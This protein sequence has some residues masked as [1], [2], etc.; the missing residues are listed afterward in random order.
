M[1]RE[2][3]LRTKFFIPY[4]SKALLNKYREIYA[5]EVCDPLPHHPAIHEQDRTIRLRCGG[6]ATVKHE[7]QGYVRLIRD[8]QV[9]GRHEEPDAGFPARKAL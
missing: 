9:E 3:R 4:I 7:T 2:L 6:R 8:V 1:N 5:P